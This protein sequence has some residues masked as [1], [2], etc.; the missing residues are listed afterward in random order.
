MIC[1]RWKWGRSHLLMTMV[2]NKLLFTDR[3]VC[4]GEAPCSNVQSTTSWMC[5][6]CIEAAEVEIVARPDCRHS[7]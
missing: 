3:Q 4:D 1:E 5:G 7:G 6:S 2:V